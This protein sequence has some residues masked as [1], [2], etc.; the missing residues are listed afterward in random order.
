MGGNTR[1]PVITTKYF[2]YWYSCVAPQIAPQ[3]LNPANAKKRGVQL[4][5]FSEVDGAT[6]STFG[7]IK[8]NTPG[9]TLHGVA[10]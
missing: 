3:L 8:K 1:I 2:F 5:A 6:F 7:R 9:T 10:R 4:K